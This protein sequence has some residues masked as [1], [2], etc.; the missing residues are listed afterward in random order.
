[1]QCGPGGITPEEVE[2]GRGSGLFPVFI[3]FTHLS[4][5]LKE[6]F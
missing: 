6:A 4:V 1:M 2:V 5:A 3:L